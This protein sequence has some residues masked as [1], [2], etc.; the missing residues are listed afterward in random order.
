MRQSADD[1]TAEE[2]FVRT[3]SGL[4][5]LAISYVLSFV[6]TGC[7]AAPFIGGGWSFILATVG[8]FIGLPFLALAVLGLLIF[9]RSVRTH[10][11]LWCV[12]APLLV[13]AAWLAADYGFKHGPLGVPFLTYLTRDGRWEAV[14]V[15]ATS[16]MTA[17]SF[18]LLEPQARWRVARARRRRTGYR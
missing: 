16:S 9:H 11:G 4:I 10:P 12:A 8:A 5:A 1:V 18:F 14:F 17:V 2:S 3:V 6:A 13:T 15:L 7:L